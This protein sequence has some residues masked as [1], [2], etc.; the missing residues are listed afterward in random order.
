MFRWTDDEG[1]DFGA[2]FGSPDKSNPS[3]S[4]YTSCFHVSMVPTASYFPSNPLPSSSSCLVLPD[5]LQSILLQLAASSISPDS[6]TCV[7]VADTGAMDHM[8][9]DK[10]AFISYKRISIESVWVTI[11]FFLC[12]AGVQ[13]S[14]LSTVNESLSV[15]PFTSL[16]WRC[17]CTA[18]GPILNSLAV[19]FLAPLSW[20]CL[21]TSHPL[22]YPLTLH[23]TVNSPMSP[24]DLQHLW[25]VSITFN[26]G[27]HRCS[28]LRN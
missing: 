26:V 8:F 20:A 2:P 9:P 4:L 27:A 6:T 3:V 16:V 12:W 21:S 15:T 10:S 13:Q 5:Q 7:A 1:L 18:F 22:S 25:R 23:P 28:T 24:L 14:S 19:A 11:P 17:R